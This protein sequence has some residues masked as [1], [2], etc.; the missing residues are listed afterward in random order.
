LFACISESFS[1]TCCP[2]GLYTQETVTTTHPASGCSC[3]ITYCYYDAP[4]GDRKLFIC[5]IFIPFGQSCDYEDFEIN[6]GFWIYVEQL[7]LGDLHSKDPFDPCG[8]GGGQSNL[9]VESSRAK[10]QRTYPDFT[11]NGY[12]IEQ[13]DDEPGLCVSIY[14]VCVDEGVLIKNPISGPTQ[15]G[16]GSCGVYNTDLDN[17]DTRCSNTCQ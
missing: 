15:T 7:V 8:Q 1:Q 5:G 9:I 2:S 12:R 3:T 4:G 16:T 10:C 14:S 6:A 17:V 11:S 13:C